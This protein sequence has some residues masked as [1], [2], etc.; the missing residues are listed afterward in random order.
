M[1]VVEVLLL[2]FSINIFFEISIQSQ[3]FNITCDQHNSSQGDCQS[4]SLETIAAKLNENATVQINIKVPW[5]I[6]ATNV[7]FTKLN[8]LLINGCDSNMT[9]ITCNTD[10]NGNSVGILFG[11]I[12]DAIKLYAL[13]FMLCGLQISSGTCSNRYSSYRSALTMLRCKNVEL[14]NI[15]IANSKGTG[16]KVLY[17]QGG[18]VL[19]ESTVFKENK[20]PQDNSE[21]LACARGGGG[22]YVVIN[23]LREPMAFHFDNCTFEN[24]VAHTTKFDFGYTNNVGEAEIGYGSGGGA[25]L[26]FKDGIRDVKVSFL[27]CKFIANQAFIGGGIT[28][29]FYGA[30]SND[31]RRNVTL[32]IGDTLFERNG[33]S[34]QTRRNTYFG[35]GAYLSFATYADGSIITDSH[36]LVRNVS[37]IGNCAELG[38]GVF[39][40]SN[41]GKQ[42]Y[43]DNEN[44]SM[45]FDNCTFKRNQ[46]HI[47]SAVEMSANIFLKLI[48]GYVIVPIFK[49]S[50]FLENVVFVNQSQNVQTTAGIGTIY[51][52]LYNINFVGSNRFESNQ[53]TPVYI[54]NGV[55]NCTMSDIH[56]VNNIGLQGGAMA[57]IGSSTMVV[58]PCKYEFINNTAIHQ[59]GAIY[60][61]L[62][63]STDYIM[64]RSCFI[65]SHYDNNGDSMGTSTTGKVN[66]TFVGNKAID[67]TAGHS[68]YATSLHPC[69][70]INNGTSKKPNY[71]LVTNISQVFSARGVHFHNDPSHPQVAT[72]GAVFHTS[73]E[74]PWMI[75]PGEIYQHGMT[76]TDDLNHSVKASLRVAVRPGN[77]KD[78]ELQLI[79]GFYT[80]TGSTIQVKGRPNHNASLFIYTVSPRQS[81]IKLSISLLKCP[82]GFKLSNKGVCDCN[83]KAYVG[84]LKCDM[85][86]FYSHLHFGY[87]I[88][89]MDTPNGSQQLV[90]SPCPFC[91]YSL[92]ALNSPHSNSEFIALPKNYTNL[93]KIVCGESRSG[94]V[95]GRCQNDYATH[96]HSP[97]FQCKAIKPNGCRFG[98]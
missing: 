56:F 7:S 51:A 66:I 31:E 73:R 63:D 64:S 42:G 3:V 33:C 18:R 65:Y 22:I 27:S 88:G 6:L 2:L 72:D 81:Y 87:W 68:I 15:V 71:T 57:L 16:L 55:V 92:G 85:D 26:S 53:G 59:G 46:A 37:F 34:Y 60:V 21:D 24:N 62:T 50:Y 93:S 9:T 52:S 70:V 39:Y 30:K 32:E 29:K 90:T 44:N 89:L 19:I 41:R 83:V 76:M 84:L 94:I 69:Q 43:N 78:T 40:Y 97:S 91:D 48:T 25:H 74:T 36:Y 79:S 96:F 28:V 14:S 23:K 80:L 4:E 77:H 82:P 11:D 75:I 1:A 5:L 8:S 49:N 58:G 98:W 38:G 61:S 20:I 54:I 67:D 12:T 47:G 17:P 95:C 35:G 13:Q 10:N 45:L 86:Q